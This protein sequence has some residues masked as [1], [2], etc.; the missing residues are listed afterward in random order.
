M[1]GTEFRR[2]SHDRG[3]HQPPVG[4][5]PATRYTP[6]V[7]ETEQEFLDVRSHGFARVAVCVPRVQVADPA[8]N[9]DAHLELLETVSRAGAHYACCP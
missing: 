3:A 8:S 4:V 7:A 6:G 9:A 1:G 2:E 5:C